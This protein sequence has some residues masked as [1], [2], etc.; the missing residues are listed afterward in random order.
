MNDT[1]TVISLDAGGG[2]RVRAIA[3][4]SLAY[5]F[6]LISEILRQYDLDPIDVL[7]VH[8]IL[9]ANVAP[10]LNDPALDRQFASLGRSEPDLLKRGIS[11][12]ALARFLNLPLE[13]VRRRAAALKRRGVVCERE[14]GLI[15]PEG[16]EFGFGDKRRLQQTN[17]ILLKRLLRGLGRVGISRLEDLSASIDI[18][19]QGGKAA[20]PAPGISRSP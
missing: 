20:L 8:A 17:I 18:N 6:G 19:G 14:D 11:R 1:T 15:V 16:N 2:D 12:A 3:R 9:N 4:H 7:I 10:I 5:G 13:T